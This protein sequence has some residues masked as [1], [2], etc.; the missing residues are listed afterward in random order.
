MLG[1]GFIPE[2][3]VHGFLKTRT[4]RQLALSF[5]K[6]WMKK[7]DWRSHS[8]EPGAILARQAGSIV[9]LI[10]REGDYYPYKMRW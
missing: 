9:K 3:G 2:I 6:R 5:S 8:I 1:R 10:N 4:R 7:I